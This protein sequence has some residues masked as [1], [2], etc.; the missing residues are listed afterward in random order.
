MAVIECVYYTVY[1]QYFPV[2]KPEFS[3]NF[4]LGRTRICELESVSAD[5]S[6]L[7]PE[8]RMNPSE[9]TFHEYILLP[10]SLEAEPEEI[11][12]DFIRQMYIVEGLT[13][14][15]FQITMKV[16]DKLPTAMSK[17]SHKTPL[18][19]LRLYDAMQEYLMPNLRHMPRATR[20]MSDEQLKMVKYKLGP[21]QWGTGKPE[22]ILA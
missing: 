12:E 14:E 8:E 20:E 1:T 7:S 10:E 19:M 16:Y 11:E 21:Y 2:K 17:D 9:E 13:E 4:I 18:E 15:D 5:F 22:M 3:G 6:D